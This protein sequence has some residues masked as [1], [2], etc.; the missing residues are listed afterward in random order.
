MKLCDIGKIRKI[1]DKWTESCDI[2]EPEVMEKFKTRRNI[3][4]VLLFFKL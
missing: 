3:Q 2:L 1:N 4:L